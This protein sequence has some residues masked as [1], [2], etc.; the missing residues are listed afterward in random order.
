[1]RQRM[2]QRRISMSMIQNLLDEGDVSTDEKIFL[3]LNTLKKSISELDY[4][5]N[6]L[7]SRRKILEKLKQRGGL[8]VVADAD[9][10]ITT[11]TYQ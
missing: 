4:E 1:M 5:I 8:V 9:T 6:I 11:Y 7:R 10:A 2:Q 3:D